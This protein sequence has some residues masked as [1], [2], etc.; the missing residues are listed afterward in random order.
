M[1]LLFLLQSP[2]FGMFCCPI[3]HAGHYTTPKLVGR[4]TS[5]VNKWNETNLGLLPIITCAVGQRECTPLIFTIHLVMLNTFLTHST[6]K[7]ILRL[8]FLKERVQNGSR[9]RRLINKLELALFIPFP[10]TTL[11]HILL[12]IC[13]SSYV[14]SHIIEPASWNRE[15]YFPETTLTQKTM[16]ATACASGVAQS[17]HYMPHRPYPPYIKLTSSLCF[18]LLGKLVYQP[19]VSHSSQTDPVKFLALQRP[20]PVIALLRIGA[21]FACPQ[22]F[23]SFHVVPYTETRHTT[24]D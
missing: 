1:K 24:N 16:H 21:F 11:I 15:K 14:A 9:A 19:F 13:K 18:L 12:T 17:V 23:P 20:F 2:Y 10:F 6:P 5:G 22:I 3:P 7:A 8:K 4:W